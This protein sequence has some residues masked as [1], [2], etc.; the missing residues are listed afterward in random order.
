MKRFSI[1][2]VCLPLYGMEISYIKRI[3]PI[4]LNWTDHKRRKQFVRAGV[5]HIHAQTQL[6]KDETQKECGKDRKEEIRATI[7]IYLTL[8]DGLGS[9]DFESFI[10]EGPRAQTILEELENGLM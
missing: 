1:L 9:C 8:L 3:L 10:I 6:L 7:H 2:M 5:S 4:A